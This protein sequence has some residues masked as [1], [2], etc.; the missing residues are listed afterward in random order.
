MMGE[1]LREAAVLVFVFGP[2]EILLVRGEPL[3]FG[4]S[5]II[6]GIAAVLLA[7]GIAVEVMRE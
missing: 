4:G 1:F 7:S 5:L 6:L 3:T 2:L